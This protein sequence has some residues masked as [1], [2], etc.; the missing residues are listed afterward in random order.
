MNHLQ[1]YD[2]NENTPP[3]SIMNLFSRISS[4]HLY[5]THSSISDHFYTKES[6]I[7]ATRNV[8][9]RVVV[10]LWIG[11]SATFERCKKNIFLKINKRKTS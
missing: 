2:I 9:S 6:H 11:I 5:K 1:P 7:Y 8:F 10:K 3:R 4:G